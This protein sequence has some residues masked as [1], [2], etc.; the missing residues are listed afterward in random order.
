MQVNTNHRE[1][2]EKA[3]FADPEDPDSAEVKL[4]DETVI[5]KKARAI[6]QT[7]ETEKRDKEF[8]AQMPKLHQKQLTLKHLAAASPA[9]SPIKGMAH[10]GSHLAIKGASSKKWTNA[11]IKLHDVHTLTK[12]AR[13]M[14]KNVHATKHEW[15]QLSESKKQTYIDRANA[16]VR[17]KQVTVDMRDKDY[18]RRIRYRSVCSVRNCTNPAYEN[19]LCKEDH[20]GGKP[21]CVQRGHSDCTCM[22]HWEPVETQVRRVPAE[23]PVQLTYLQSAAAAFKFACVDFW[24]VLELAFMDLYGVINLML[25]VMAVL[26]MDSFVKENGQYSTVQ[27]S[28]VCKTRRTTS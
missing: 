25:Q 4:W 8:Q 15:Q 12:T 6:W 5:V 3:Y 9:A 28:T 17:H 11:S 7:D 19:H 2:L 1:M 20:A 14:L 13:D 16:A 26:S 27:Y 10:R 21:E 24:A 18:M 23:K 22:K